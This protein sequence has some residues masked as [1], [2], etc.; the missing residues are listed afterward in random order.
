MYKTELVREIDV[1]VSKK[2][3]G[4]AETLCQT[5]LSKYPNDL[6]ITLRLV[7]ALAKQQ[8][9]DKGVSISEALCQSYPNDV[10]ALHALLDIYIAKER[11]Q[12]AELAGKRWL[13]QEGNSDFFVQMRLGL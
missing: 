1:L 13:G 8:L 7:N 3:W 12:D 11:F 9:Y 5:A 4:E 10:R 6:P 2:H